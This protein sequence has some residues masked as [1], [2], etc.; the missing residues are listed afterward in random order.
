MEARQSFA[1]AISIIEMLRTQTAGVDE[2]PQ[3]YFEGRLLA[4]HGLLSLLVK[5]NQNWEAL[6]FAERVKTRVLLDAL[7]Q[8]RTKFQKAM[9]AEEQGQEFRLKSELTRLNTQLTHATQADKPDAARIGEIK[10]QLEKSRFSYEAFQDLLYAAHP[11]LKVNRGEASIIN[12]EEL[13]AL[14]PDS[15]SALLEY[16]VT[17][18]AT[19]LFVVTKP[20]SQAA[21]ETRVFTIPIK[22]TDLAKQIEGFRRQLAERNLR[23]RAPARKLYDLLLEPA[24]ALLRGKSSLVIAPDD[25]LW[26]LP[27][28]ALLDERDRYLLERSAVSYA[29]SLTVLREM[30]A[31]RDHRRGETGPATLLA[32]G[33][34]LIGQETVERARLSLRDGKLSPLP[35]AEAEVRALGRLYGA[36]RSKV[37]IGPNA[38]ED[39]LKA[40]AGEAG[41]IH[42][43]THGVLNNAA[44]LYSYLALARGNKNEDGLLEAWEL[45]QLDLKAELAVLS[46]C[47]TARGRTSAGEGVI[48]LTWALFV[49]GAPATVVSQWEVE[50]ASTR[51]LMLGFHRRLQAPRSAGRQTK[52]ESLRQ[53]ALKLMK[54]PET[55]HPFYWAG[56][57]LVGD[58]R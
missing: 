56:F 51:D 7:Q 13:A 1:E 38:S 14:L 55:N 44:P 11:E 15:T 25:R 50:S 26:E 30:R 17:D 28:Q 42:F 5:G 53:A 43:A 10:S 21:V 31:R 41:I 4:H 54:N 29:P 37:F 12:A 48:G 49:A 24:Q 9:T 34:P 32:L 58:G 22:Q 8:G 47:E 18:E 45:M 39:R 19:Y 2:G 23:V 52:A 16:V 3:R 20:Q 36:R 35:E 33:N 40:E 6:V 46:A 57:V 27:F